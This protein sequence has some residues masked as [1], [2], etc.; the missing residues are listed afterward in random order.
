VRQTY[1]TQLAILAG[2]GVLIMTIVFSAVQLGGV[3]EERVLARVE[4]APDIPHPVAGREDI[5]NTCHGLDGIRPYPLNHAGWPNESCQQCHQQMDAQMIP[6]PIEGCEGCDTCHGL[7]GIRPYPPNHEGWPNESCTECHFPVD[8]IIFTLITRT[9]GAI[10]A[11]QPVL[12]ADEPE[13]DGTP[14][15]ADT[16][17]P[18]P[19]PQA[20]GTPT[21]ADAPGPTP[22]PTPVDASPITHPIEGFEDCLQCHAVDSPIR[23]APPDHEG[24]TNEICT[25]C[26]QPS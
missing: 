3:A 1:A 21:P 18:T 19:D 8:P 11:E 15:P 20:E 2:I 10:V 23:P 24:W 7:D 26:H 12:P 13:P 22:V 9:V 6:H 17:G 14:A 25:L 5:C 4:A 16:P